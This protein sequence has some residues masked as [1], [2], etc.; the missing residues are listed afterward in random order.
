MISP[1][2]V[3]ISYSH[4]DDALLDV[5]RAHLAPLKQQGLIADWHDRRI[6]PGDDWNREINEQ[7]ERCQIV[8]LLLSANFFASDYINGVEVAAALRRHTTGEARVIPVV[9]RAVDWEHTKLGALQALPTNAKPVASWRDRDQAFRDVAR[10]VRTVLTSLGSAPATSPT[11][12]EY[13]T[14]TRGLFLNHTAF[15]REDRQE[16]FRARTGIPLDHYDIRVVLDAEEPAMLDSVSH[17]EYILHPAYPVPVQVRTA[18]RDRRTKFLLKELA[19]GEYLLRAKVYMINGS[20]PICLER[21]I[22]LWRSGPEL[23]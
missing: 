7:L 14:P 9:L 12:I 21:Y 10:G 2:Q 3:F 13:E 17:V 8:L 23:Q 15:L 18:E 16:E 19:N 1:V 6:L 11:N 5:L 20:A 4:K 22:T